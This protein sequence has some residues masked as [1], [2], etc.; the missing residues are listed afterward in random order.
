MNKDICVNCGYDEAPIY[1]ITS[2]GVVYCQETCLH[3]EYSET[4]INWLFDNGL[5]EWKEREEVKP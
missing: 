5:I 4:E 3:G 1:L 2:E